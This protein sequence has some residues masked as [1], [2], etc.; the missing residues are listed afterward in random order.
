MCIKD[1]CL[2]RA[3]EHGINVYACVFTCG[4][5]SESRKTD[6]GQAHP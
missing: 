1:A 3:N 6:G 5:L 4:F 2:L